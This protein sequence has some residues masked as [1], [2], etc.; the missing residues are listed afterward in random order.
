MVWCTLCTVL[1]AFLYSQNNDRIKIGFVNVSPSFNTVSYK[2]QL[3]C[4]HSFIIRFLVLRIRSIFTSNPRAHICCIRLILIPV[5]I[6]SSL[7]G[8]RSR[9]WTLLSIFSRTSTFFSCSLI[10]FYFP[11]SFTL[12]FF[13]SL[14]SSA[15][16]ASLL[17]LS[18]YLIV[19]LTFKSFLL[20]FSPSSLLLHTLKLTSPV[21][22][23]SKL[24]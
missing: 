24:T 18:P 9:S 17:P 15:V 23:L 10:L 22:T 8:K 5:T 21:M 19:S 16:P 6:R 2:A 20:W 12:S 4:T 14:G 11:T 7:R 13:T 1:I 3:S